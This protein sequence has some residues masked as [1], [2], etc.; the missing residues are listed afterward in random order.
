MGNFEY[1]YFDLVIKPFESQILKYKD[2]D[3]T[4]LTK[5]VLTGLEIISNQLYNISIDL[6]CK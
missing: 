6:R 1:E 5:E 4:E 2:S 3:I